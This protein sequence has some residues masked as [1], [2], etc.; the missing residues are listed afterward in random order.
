MSQDAL[1]KNIKWSNNLEDHFSDTAE[2]S[3]V[4]YWLH[5]RSEEKLS[6]ITTFLDLPIIILGILN[7]ATSVGS[8]SLFGDAAWAPIMIGGI[9]LLTSILNAI[10]S[11]FSWQRK[12]EAHK[13][14]SIQYAKLYRFLC[15]EMSLPREER[16]T[17]KELLAYCKEQIDRLAEI[18][19]LI[20]NS[21]IKDF[22]TKFS[23]L[24]DISFPEETGGL[25]PVYVFKDEPRQLHRL[26]TTPYG[27]CPPTIHLRDS[28]RLPESFLKNDK[29]LQ[30]PYSGLEGYVNPQLS[31]L[32]ESIQDVEQQ[33]KKEEII[34]INEAMAIADEET[35]E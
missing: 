28:Y 35:K 7:G 15:I 1:D 24:K 20:P 12:A 6:R 19:P 17:P 3:Q 33:M 4:Y 31:G 9:V 21:V 22:R 34:I 2:K 32:K 5:K 10:S 14:S 23:D 29:M 18:S 13:I 27:S 16:L 30:K 26:D 11:Y 25:R 8:Q